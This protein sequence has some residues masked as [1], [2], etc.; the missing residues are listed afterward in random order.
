MKQKELYLKVNVSEAIGDLLQE[1]GEVQSQDSPKFM[2]G[3]Y[4]PAQSSYQRYMRRNVQ[5]VP[6][7][8]SH[9]FAKPRKETKELFVALMNA[10]QEAIRI[11]PKMNLVDGLKKTRCDTIKVEVYLSN[12]YVNT[13]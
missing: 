4:G 3:V 7:P 13:R 1:Y 11:T 9:R 5:G 8:N 10:S 2:N 12:Y 6:I